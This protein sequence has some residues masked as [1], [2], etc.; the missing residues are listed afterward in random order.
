MSDPTIDAEAPETWK[1]L[2]PPDDASAPIYKDEQPAPIC[3]ECDIT[4]DQLPGGLNL[5]ARLGAHRYRAHGVPGAH[6]GSHKTRGRKVPRDT[7]PGSV[8]VELKSPAARAKKTDPALDRVEERARH[9]AEGIAVV[10]L[11]SQQHEDAAD[12]ERH[13]VP[14]SK[15]VRNLAEYE[16]WLKNLL[17]AGGES[18]DRVMAWLGF[19]IAT[20]AMLTPILVR[21]DLVPPQVQQLLSM[22]PTEPPAEAPREPVAA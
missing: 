3:P 16:D 12:I 10:L 15:S 14:W 9:I 4:E 11:L 22:V 20:G 17:S 6:A 5:A 2:A 18:S 13:K 7:A 1:H 8:R 21:H 19:L